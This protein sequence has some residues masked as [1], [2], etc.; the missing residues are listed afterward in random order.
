MRL[1][2]ITTV[3]ISFSFLCVGCSS[4]GTQSQSKKLRPGEPDPNKHLEGATPV[5]KTYRLP[6][7]SKKNPDRPNFR[8]DT[9]S[10]TKKQQEATPK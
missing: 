1:L 9:D 4:S 2:L 7:G 10:N 8:S 6:E 3:A 5:L